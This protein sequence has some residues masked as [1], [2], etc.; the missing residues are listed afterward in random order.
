MFSMYKIINNSIIKLKYLLFFFFES[1]IKN[2]KKTL[3]TYFMILI[4][5]KKYLI[6]F[7]IILIL[8]SL[9]PRSLQ[10]MYGKK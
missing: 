4:N 5:H 1:M 3:I 9:I 8:F 7:S 10:K 2:L 6:N